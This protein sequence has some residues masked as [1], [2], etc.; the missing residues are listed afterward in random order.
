MRPRDKGL[1]VLLGVAL[2]A[3]G[4]KGMS[5][6]SVIRRGNAPALT[7]AQLRD[8]A[9]AAGFT[10]GALDIAV[11]VA[12]AESR[13]YPQAVGDPSKGGSYGLWQVNIP[14]H[15]EYRGDPSVLFDPATAA[16]A[17]YKISRAGTDWSP[18]STYN[19]KEY[20]KWMPATAAPTT[21]AAFNFVRVPLSHEDAGVTLQSGKKYAAKVQLT[22][23]ESTFG[24]AGAVK[25]KL[26]AAGFSGVIVQSTPPAALPGETP[27]VDGDT[28]WAL[29]TWSKPST[30][31]PLPIQVKAVWSD[32]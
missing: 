23:L 5:G 6:S 4:R 24:T 12:M 15:P 8:V 32:A 30:V 21:H 29:G 27:F 22:G 10:G 11:A 20:L 28:Y 18:W 1:A 26:E 13:G 19:D 9:A 16:A 31:K 25:S 3:F 14:N 2:F 17:A 7:L